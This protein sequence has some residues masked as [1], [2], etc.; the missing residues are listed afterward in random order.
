MN[1]AFDQS[2]LGIFQ[3]YAAM[4]FL[5]ACFRL[6][7]AFPGRL[8]S[9]WLRCCA[10][11]IQPS[12]F[13]VE[14]ISGNF[15]GVFMRT[16]SGGQGLMRMNTHCL[17]AVTPKSRR[18]RDKEAQGR[19]SPALDRTW[20]RRANRLVGDL[21]RD[22]SADASYASPPVFLDDLQLTA[23]R[24]AISKG[25]IR[26]PIAATGVEYLVMAQQVDAYNLAGG[27]RESEFEIAPVVSAKWRRMRIHDPG[28]EPV[29]S[30]VRVTSKAPRSFVI[31]FFD[32]A[33]DEVDLV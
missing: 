14:M 32:A 7:P 22:L 25:R 27:S 1:G 29:P 31:V 6:R 26:A 8:N 2:I 11:C 5:A 3:R 16:T 20:L 24:P 15:V 13:K 30:A 23:S 21:D 18:T 17:L 4:A 28:I 12:D 19:I 9:T 33:L 10:T